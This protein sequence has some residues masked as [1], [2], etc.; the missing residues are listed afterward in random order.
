MEQVGQVGRVR[1]GRLSWLPQWLER[2][3]HFCTASSSGQ[4][5]RYLL[6]APLCASP[7]PNT[8]A[9]ALLFILLAFQHTVRMARVCASL[10]PKLRENLG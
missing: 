1:T 3:R 9:A 2:S 8:R 7:V 10:V 4:L 6:S 5:Q